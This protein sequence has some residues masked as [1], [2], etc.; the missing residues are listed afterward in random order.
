MAINNSL[1]KNEAVSDEE[2][3]DVEESHSEK[4][5]LGNI[6]SLLKNV[7]INQ[8]L[9]LLNSI[10]ISQFS[11]LLGSSS[12]NSE[13]NNNS[14]KSS[15]EIEVLNAI[16]PM[17]NAQRGELIDLVMQIYAISRILK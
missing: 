5:N 17:V 1:I 9:G 12:V 11:S 2:V 6:A 7:D 16:K 3:I 4:S 15:R 8:I 10:D 13:G 14:R